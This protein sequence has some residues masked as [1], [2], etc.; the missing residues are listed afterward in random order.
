M[1]LSDVPGDSLKCGPAVL[2]A[3][4]ILTWVLS[5]AM[6]ASVVPGPSNLAKTSRSVSTNA[7]GTVLSSTA[8]MRTDFSIVLI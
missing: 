2:V 8:P 1:V 7:V 3:S 5:S 4:A 6:Y